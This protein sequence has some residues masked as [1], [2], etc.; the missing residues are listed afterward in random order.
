MSFSTGTKRRRELS[1]S[2]PTKKP[3]TTVSPLQV[4]KAL[5]N[6]YVKKSD[7]ENKYFHAEFATTAYPVAGS[8]TASWVNAIGTSIFIPPLGDDNNSREGRMCMLTKINIRGMIDCPADATTALGVTPFC[9]IIVADL[10]AAKGQ[11]PLPAQLMSSNGVFATMNPDSFG[12]WKILKDVIVQLPYMA[13]TEGAV[14]GSF[15]TEGIQQAFQIV[16]K[17][18]E[19]LKVKFTN[20]DGVGVVGAVSEHNIIVASMTSNTSNGPRLTFHSVCSFKDS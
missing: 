8:L 9:R 5:D 15:H 4:S 12:Q 13:S 18:K 6:R 19:P 20:I 7:M 10:I 11:A 1:V 14:A 17:F 16:H 2:K 3:R